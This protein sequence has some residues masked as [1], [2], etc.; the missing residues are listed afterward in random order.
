MDSSPSRTTSGVITASQI[1]LNHDLEFW[2]LN[3]VIMRSAITELVQIK[4]GILKGGGN[5]PYRFVYE[6]LI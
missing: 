2:L 4:R 5:L 3:K 1:P 6:T